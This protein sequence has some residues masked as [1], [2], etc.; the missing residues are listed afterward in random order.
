MARL[1]QLEHLLSRQEDSLV[2]VNIDLLHSKGVDAANQFLQEVLRKAGVCHEKTARVDQAILA[3]APPP[4]SSPENSR[5]SKVVDAVASSADESG[6][7]VFAEMRKKAKIRA[8][9]RLDSIQIEKEE[10]A[11]I[12]QV[13][14]DSI[15]VEAKKAAEIEFQKNQELAKQLAAEIYGT[16]EK[17]KVRAAYDLFNTKKPYLHQYLIQDAFSMLENTVLQA[18]DPKWANISLEIAYLT[19]ASSGTQPPLSGLSAA[20]ADKATP[21]SDKNREKAEGII[22]KVYDMLEHNDV[23][24]AARQFTS[25]KSFL[26]AYLE[27]ET[28]D[29]LTAT[30]SQASQ[31]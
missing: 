16:I 22:A 9:F 4:A 21:K 20:E 23:N 26:R 27:K 11:R 10:R 3:V 24:G 17:N 5:V 14:L 28:Y 15:D 31:K 13:R 7:D 30:V 1:N 29:V 25:E 2:K 8:Q 12:V 18:V 19:P 6:I